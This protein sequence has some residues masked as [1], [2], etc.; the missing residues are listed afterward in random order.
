MAVTATVTFKM[1][2]PTLTS[3]SFTNDVRTRVINAIIAALAARGIIVPPS[4]VYVTAIQDSSASRRLAEPAVLG[5]RALQTAAKDAVALTV[6]IDYTAATVLPNTPAAASAGSSTGSAAAMAALTTELTTASS[7]GSA[8]VAA[9]IGTSLAAAG[10][11][12]QTSASSAASQPESWTPPAPASSSGSGSSSSGGGMGAAIGG[13][14]GGLLV[15]GII[16]AVVYFKVIKPRNAGG[17][18]GKAGGSST[19]T[20]AIQMQANP[21]GNGSALRSPSAH[22]GNS[23]APTAMSGV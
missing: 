2:L 10:I 4:A 16:G 3:A 15:I 18:G 11:I 21:L 8:T 12:P 20:V 22:H 5:A 14:V 1:L 7:S 6:K 17:A 9:S 13:A 19:V 23:F